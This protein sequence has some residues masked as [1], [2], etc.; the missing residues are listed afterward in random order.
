MANNNSPSTRSPRA[1]TTQDPPPTAADLPEFSELEKTRLVQICV[2][3]QDLYRE[4]YLGYKNLKPFWMQVAAE[5]SNVF[6]GDYSWLDCERVVNH[7]TD[8]RRKELAGL[9]EPRAKDKSEITASVMDWLRGLDDDHRQHTPEPLA[10]QPSPTRRKRRAVDFDDFGPNYPSSSE[11]SAMID[12]Q[13]ERDKA[14]IEALQKIGDAMAQRQQRVA[15]LEARVDG[16]TRV[17]E[18]QMKLFEDVSQKL[19]E[20]IVALDRRKEPI[21]QAN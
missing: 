6:G 14:M 3:K 18:S 11:D 9:R 2:S 12:L 7:L 21:S 15:E 8:A 4:L 16:L 20:I 17:V 19:N 1:T 10:S 13:I 5:M